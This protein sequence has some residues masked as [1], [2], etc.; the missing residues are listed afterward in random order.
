[1]QLTLKTF[2]TVHEIIIWKKERGIYRVSADQFYL[3][4]GNILNSI[5]KWGI[6]RMT[7]LLRINHTVTTTSYYQTIIYIAI[8]NDAYWCHLFCVQGIS[9]KRDSRQKIVLPYSEVVSG[10][11]AASRT[12]PTILPWTSSEKTNVIIVMIVGS[13][14]WRWSGLVERSELWDCGLS[15]G[16]WNLH[17]IHPT[18]IFG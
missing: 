4:V 12:S 10:I 6:P 2:I 17:L 11:S 1:V 18:C 13:L 7:N 5:R 15:F 3:F 16:T 9:T 8:H 14:I